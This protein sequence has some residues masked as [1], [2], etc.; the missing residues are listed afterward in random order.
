MHIKLLPYSLAT[1]LTLFVAT[2]FPG[3]VLAEDSGWIEKGDLYRYGKFMFREELVPIKIECRFT[4]GK[5]PKYQI[6]I[7]TK[8]VTGLDPRSL[9]IFTQIGLSG[10]KPRNPRKPR[11]SP[12]V[13]SVQHPVAGYWTGCTIPTPYLVY[14]KRTAR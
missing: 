6:R 13:F 1:A 5:V 3:H 8:H 9:A 2:M 4:K 7:W 12:S 10:P 11:L 14:G